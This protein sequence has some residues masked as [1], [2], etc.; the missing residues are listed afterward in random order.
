MSPNDRNEEDEAEEEDWQGYGG[1][2]SLP[3]V[4]VNL[5]PRRSRQ[6]YDKEM[7]IP[8]DDEE[9]DSPETKSRQKR[10]I[11]KQDSQMQLQQ[12]NIQLLLQQT[13]TQQLQQQL[14]QLQKQQRQQ[15][16]LEKEKEKEE[17]TEKK[18]RRRH[19][20]DDYDD[21]VQHRRL[22]GYDKVSSSEEDYERYPKNSNTL[23]LIFVLSFSRLF[24]FSPPPL[25]FLF[26][27]YVFDCE[28]IFTFERKENK[29]RE[30]DEIYQHKSVCTSH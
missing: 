10:R 30:R 6:R 4:P 26:S 11:T 5:T 2:Q 25:W 16:E 13:L 14:D 21:L 18:V 20:E 29:W 7:M 28:K 22:Q 24:F 12:Q 23:P 1:E 8:S 27:F 15:K 17:G 3:F 9:E 19:H